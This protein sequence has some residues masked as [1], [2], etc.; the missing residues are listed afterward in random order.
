MFGFFLAMEGWKKVT[1]MVAFYM[2]VIELQPLEPFMTAY[3][4]GPDVNVSISEVI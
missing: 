2:F 1:Y 3:Q 4:I